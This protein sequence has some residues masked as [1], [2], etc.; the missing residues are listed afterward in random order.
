[1][2]WVQFVAFIGAP[3]YALLVAWIMMCH[4]KAQKGY[5]EVKDDLAAFRTAVAEN[6]ATK[7]H[8]VAVEKTIMHRLERIEV[9]IDTIVGF[10]GKK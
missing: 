2:T 3:A 4:S 1:M 6:Y 7:S 5:Q 9:K 10:G 8:I